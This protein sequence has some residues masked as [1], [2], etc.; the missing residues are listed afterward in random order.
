[1]LLFSGR[2]QSET[3][4]VVV[5]PVGNASAEKSSYKM[6]FLFHVPM[7]HALIIIEVV[8]CNNNSSPTPH[9]KDGV[10]LHGGH[11]LQ[12]LYGPN[13]CGDIFQS[14]TNSPPEARK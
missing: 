13:S 10:E 14:G 8:R 6:R 12:G 4:L 9:C 11:G 1:M 5:F 7:Y 3:K 2:K